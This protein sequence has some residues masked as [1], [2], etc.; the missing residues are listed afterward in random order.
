MCE[1]CACPKASGIRRWSFVAIIFGAGILTGLMGCARKATD[2]PPPDFRI[3]VQNA[4]G[5]GVGSAVIWRGMEVGRVDGVT[6]DKG[7]VRIDTDMHE[8]YR[9]KFRE[10]LRARPSRGFLG[11]G[12]ATLDLYGGDD[13][14]RGVLVRGAFVSEAAVTDTISTRQMQVVGFL[15]LG[16]ILF[17]VLLR[18][19]HKMVAFAL[20][21]ALLVFAGWFVHRQW[22]KHGAEIIAT[23]MEMRLSDVAKALLTQEAAKE[24][25]FAAQADMA[26]A[27]RE[28]G[29]RGT[30][31]I[32]AGTVELRAALARKADELIHQ[33]KDRAAEEV[34][35][36]RDSVLTE[37]DSDKP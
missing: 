4:Q 6:M 13:P 8:E 12:P 29:G 24:A 2:K 20:A 27:M 31:R 3:H 34:R 26:E 30:Q 25:W 17:L 36:L 37:A 28:V 10:G 5:L 18:I 19:M 11:R 21:A 32:Q 15:A 7:M 1:L 14:R 35:S 33:G 23:R 16:V 9:G 22:Q